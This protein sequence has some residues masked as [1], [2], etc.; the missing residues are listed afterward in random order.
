MRRPRTLARA[1]L[2]A[3]ALLGASLGASRAG[4]QA[5]GPQRQFLAIEPYYEH[6]RLDVGMN[7]VSA[8]TSLNGYGA[9]LWIN[10]A[11]FHFPLNSSIAL[12]MTY[13]PSRSQSGP[14]QFPA[15]PISSGFSVLHY[16]AQIDQFFVRRPFAGF[17]DPFVSLGV[18]RFRYGFDPSIPIVGG[19]TE[20]HLSLSPGIGLRIPIPNRLEIRGDV[21][22]MFL[23]NG[24]TDID[25]TQK[26]TSNL[27]IQ[28]GLGLT[29]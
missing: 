27:V 21:R 19:S 17:L 10:G 14:Q 9:R 1:A 7:D 12:F 20:S 28:G 18:G 23:L 5:L 8:T 2:A 13:A 22:D 24:R 26:T 29:F 15:G 4:A 25:G 16:G 11:P 3:A 6:T